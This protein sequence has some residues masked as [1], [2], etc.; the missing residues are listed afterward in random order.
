MAVRQYYS[1]PDNV[2]TTNFVNATNGDIITTILDAYPLAV[3]DCQKHAKILKSG[4]FEKD[5]ATIWNVLKTELTYKRDLDELQTIALPR[6]AF[7]RVKNDCKSFSLCAAG[8]VGAMGYIAVIRFAGY[9]K[10]NPYPSHV[11]A[12]AVDPVS[13]RKIII[14]GCAPYFNWEKQSEFK[15]D[16]PMNVVT[17]SDRVSDMER[18]EKIKNNLPRNAR[19]K[20]SRVKDLAAQKAYYEFLNKGSINKLPPKGT[21]EREAAIKVRKEKAKEGLKKVGH[22][23]MYMALLLGRGAFMACIRLNLNGMASKLKKLMDANKL[24]PVEDKWYKLGGIIKLFRNA[25]TKGANK[26]PLFL[27]KKA[28]ARFDKT[29]QT[30]IN[31]I[32]T[33]H[34]SEITTINS[35][36]LSAMAA[37]ALPVIAAIVPIMVKAFGGMGAKGKAEGMELTAQ[38]TDIVNKNYTTD[39]PVPDELDYIEIPETINAGEI[40]AELGKMAGEGI[41]KL[42]G[43]INKKNPKVGAVIQKGGQAAEDYATGQ[44]IRTSGYGAGIKTVR[45]TAGSLQKYLLPAAAVGLGVVFL[46]RK[47]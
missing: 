15:K 44:Y 33:Q 29:M 45:D 34:V 11:Y 31:G 4:D 1:R 7:S 6:M 21:P 36:A 30:K 12:V 27:S 41:K 39:E 16:Y 28:R 23:A 22:G 9:K 38:A 46:M 20:L 25:I 35:V 26:K 43:K 37:T 47:K 2:I 13:K 32:E 8:L 10:N 3:M 18:I 42:A 14:D 40:W 17:L 19:S 5:C 24:A